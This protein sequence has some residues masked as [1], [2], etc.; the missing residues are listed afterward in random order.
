[1]FLPKVVKVRQHFTGEKINDIDE[2]VRSEFSKSEINQTIKPGMSIAITAG[3]R[4]ITNI[5]RITR[6][7]VNEV[8]NLGAF[9][10]IVPAMGSHGGATAEGQIEVLESLGIT[11]EYCNAPIKAT[12]EVENLGTT[13]NGADIYMDKSAYETDGVILVNR[14]KLHT[15]FSSNIESGLMKIASI[16]LGNHKQ[17]LKIHARGTSG[18]KEDMPEVARGIFSS[19]KVLFG[20]GLVENAF[21]DTAIIEAIPVDNIQSREVELLQ[22]AK[23]LFPSLP[24]DELDTLL[25][26]E[27]GKDY[28]GSGLDTNVIGRLLIDGEEE[29]EK[30]NYT[31]IIASD[32]SEASH[33][34]STG[35]GL[36]DL[37]TKRLYEKI[38]LTKMNEN[39][40][41]TTFLKRANI[42]MVRESDKDAILTSMKCMYHVTPENFKFMRIK[43]TLHIEEMY[44]STSLIPLIKTLENM[45]IISQP[46]EMEFDEQGYFK[47]F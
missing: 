26:D 25:I 4:G 34:N 30:P 20:V 21:E 36:A 14:I 40:L 31:Y 37:T 42:P 46:K 1:M 29:P 2:K 18:L 3:S 16:G 44:V 33:G 39:V 17:A 38:D 10:V 12:M 43:N 27:I 19:G 22:E 11:E 28:S 32:L 9:P 7:I 13:A 45:E 41:T 15:D 23:R 47:S 8:K 5:A 6:A 35:I 24:I